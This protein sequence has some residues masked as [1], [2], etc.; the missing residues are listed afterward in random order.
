MQIEQATSRS[1][2][3]SQESIAPDIIDRATIE[4]MHDEPRDGREDYIRYFAIARTVEDGKTVVLYVNSDG[5]RGFDR[6]LP[7]PVEWEALP[8]SVCVPADAAVDPLPDAA[9][10][11]V[12]DLRKEH[13]GI[14][15]D[16]DR[17]VDWRTSEGSR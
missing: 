12:T 17:A 5:T 15:I 4:R 3:N 1:A 6:E 11:V 9:Q 14:E 7:F 13:A 10:N 16:E 8:R 2:E